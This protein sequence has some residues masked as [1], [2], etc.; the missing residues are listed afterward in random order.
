MRKF[1]YIYF[2]TFIV[3]HDRNCLSLLR[4]PSFMPGVK[5]HIFNF[6]FPLTY[7]I[8]NFAGQQ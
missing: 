7:L 3:P 5:I 6:V 4:V 8:S 1:S 2:N